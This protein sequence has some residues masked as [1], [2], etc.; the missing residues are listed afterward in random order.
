[1]GLPRRQR[2]M[3]AKARIQAKKKNKRTQAITAGTKEEQL[4]GRL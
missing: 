1:M 4:K 2:S 3:L